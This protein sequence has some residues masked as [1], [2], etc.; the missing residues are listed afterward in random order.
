MPNIHTITQS[1]LDA[2]LQRIE[3]KCGADDANLIR[4][5]IALLEAECNRWREMYEQASDDLML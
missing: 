2:A 5:R 1:D 4:A 3:E